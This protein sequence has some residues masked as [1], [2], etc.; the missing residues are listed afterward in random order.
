MGGYVRKVGLMSNNQLRLRASVGRVPLSPTSK[1]SS[2]GGRFRLIEDTPHML[3]KLENNPW[4]DLFLK[5]T[6]DEAYIVKFC[7][8]KANCS[9]RPSER[10]PASS[11]SEDTPVCIGGW[12][13]S[14]AG[15]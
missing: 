11:G 13:Q 7:G 10:L 15:Y 12:Y 14:S 5:Q 2:L 3:P 9:D 1:K 6:R 4:P 8:K